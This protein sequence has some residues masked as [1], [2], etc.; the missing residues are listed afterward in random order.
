MCQL[1]VLWSLYPAPAQGPKPGPPKSKLDQPQRLVVALV[2]PLGLEASQFRPFWLRS[3][4][5]GLAAIFADLL[6]L[7]PTGPKASVSP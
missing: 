6:L 5:Q 2:Q 1:P 3:Y 4:P 7:G